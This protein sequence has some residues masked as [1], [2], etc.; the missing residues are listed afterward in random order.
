M[1]KRIQLSI[2]GIAAI[3]VLQETTAPKT[4]ERMWASIRMEE[5]LKHVRW[6]GGAGYILAS[7]LRDLSFPHLTKS[8]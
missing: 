8:R 7:S 5:T 2:E 4:V 3:A 1:P 6:S